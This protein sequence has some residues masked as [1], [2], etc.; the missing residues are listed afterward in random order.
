MRTT[1][2]IAEKSETE[3]GA[4]VMIKLEFYVP[5]ESAQ[6]VKNALFNAGAGKIGN[7]EKCSWE[8]KGT[9]QFQPMPNSNP[10]IGEINK[11]TKIPELKVEM[12]CK[13]EI[14][15]DVI[16]ALIKAHPYETPAYWV[17]EVKV[18]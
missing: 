16:Q 4:E 11:L 14:I 18:F 5:E 7:Y 1:A 15:K 12:V 2:K 10:T 17:Q 6:T 9:G 3:T 13:D 8:T